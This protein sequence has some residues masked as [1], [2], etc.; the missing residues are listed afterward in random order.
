MINSA[1][2]GSYSDCTYHSD[3]VSSPL[4]YC[5]I[6]QRQKKMRRTTSMAWAAIQTPDNVH[7]WLWWLFY[8]RHNHYRNIHQLNRGTTSRVLINIILI[9][10]II[11]MVVFPV[12]IIIVMIIITYV[13]SSL[14]KS[15]VQLI[16][17]L[18]NLNV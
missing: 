1:L 6:W 10:K 2:G 14:F 5:L 9:I 8:Y 11:I 12:T 13:Y 7:W 4:S 3:S 18:F 16:T 15:Y 17:I